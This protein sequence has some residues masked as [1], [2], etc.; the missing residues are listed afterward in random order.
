[1]KVDMSSARGAGIAAILQKIAAK[2]EPVS[3][4]V[5]TGVQHTVTRRAGE[6]N[7]GKRRPTR[8]KTT[9]IS[10]QGQSRLSP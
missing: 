6:T 2:K 5:I 4:A 1:M 3:G 8:Q 10:I 7:R 9:D